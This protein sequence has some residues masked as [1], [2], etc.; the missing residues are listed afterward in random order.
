MEDFKPAGTI[1]FNRLIYAMIA[2]VFL[3]ILTD[4]GQARELEFDCAHGHDT[5]RVR[6]VADWDALNIRSQPRPA[7]RVVG[8][9]DAHGSGVHCLGPCSGIW[10]QVSWRGI[11]GWTNMKYLG[12]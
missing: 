9:I 1:T 7:L 6:N 2:I 10:C 3:V 4:N 8:R 11:V 12:E 5:Y